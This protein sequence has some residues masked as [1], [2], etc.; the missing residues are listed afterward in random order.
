MWSKRAADGSQ[1]GVFTIGTYPFS[2]LL[3][4]RTLEH[5]YCNSKSSCMQ[6][7]PDVRAVELQV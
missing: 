4:N 7:L 6:M 3:W 1:I 5:Y 2:S